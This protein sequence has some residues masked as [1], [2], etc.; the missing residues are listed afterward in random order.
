MCKNEVE[1]I[2]SNALLTYVQQNTIELCST[3]IHLLF[4]RQI[5]YIFLTKHQ[6]KLKN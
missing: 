1:L 4:G 6:L 5:L 3:R 2:I